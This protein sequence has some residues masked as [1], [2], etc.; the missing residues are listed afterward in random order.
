[1]THSE[2]RARCAQRRAALWLAASVSAL[3]LSV[4]AAGAQQALAQRIAAVTGD[5]ALHF[6]SRPDVCGSGSGGINFNSHHGARSTR[7]DPDDGWIYDCE[8][9]PVL[10]RLSV[11]NGTV[12]RLRTHVGGRYESSGGVTDLGGVGTREAVEYFLELARTAESRVARD[13]IL[14]VALADSV[15][16]APSLITLARDRDRP[17]ELRKQ[18]LFW[19][20]QVGEESV[21]EPVR[22]IANDDSEEE[23]MRKQA[24]FVLS[25]L[26]D[27]AG[28][29]TLMD[30]ARNGKSMPVRK[31]ALFW[32]G[33]G[34]APTPEL[35]KMYRQLDEREL[36]KQMI[37]V[38]SQR[39]DSAAIDGLIDIARS[40]ADHDLRK[41]AFFWLGQ[42]DDPRVV[43]LL[44]S[45]LER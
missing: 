41:Q 3:L 42:K 6:A 29:T 7:N 43:A 35:L 17:V 10:V 15:T 18:A 16:V 33:Q 22:A 9:G 19:A 44:S 37:F 39:D 8:R 5:V 31:Q 27:G 36:R 21:L 2:L 28:L 1:M 34:G 30:M 20:G 11:A 38:L 23:S 45:I 4:P 13:A 14:P 32:A 40:D 25:Q 12:T 24:T 26:P